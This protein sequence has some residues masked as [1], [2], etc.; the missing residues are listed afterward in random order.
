MMDIEKASAA[1]LEE[2]QRII[3]DNRVSRAA[4]LSVLARGLHVAIEEER[5]NRRA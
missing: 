5:G 1:M 4:F 3:G 2:M